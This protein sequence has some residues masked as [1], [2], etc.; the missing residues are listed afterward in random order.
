[1]ELVPFP[2]DFDRG[3]VHRVLK[4]GGEFHM[5]DLEGP[6][7]AGPEHQPGWFERLLHAH[8]HLK[9]NSAANVIA[10]MKEAGFADPAKVGCWK[11]LVG[12]VAYYKAVK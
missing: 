12:S 9:E 6:E 8:G 7:D 3:E 4:P 5:M 10:L 11:R 1:V 2:V